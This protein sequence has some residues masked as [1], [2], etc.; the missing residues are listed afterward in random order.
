MFQRECS[1]LPSVSPTGG[2]RCES[3]ALS[4]SCRGAVSI[5]GVH[6]P[7]WAASGI[8]Q[9]Y[10]EPS[11]VSGINAAIQLE[12]LNVLESYSRTGLG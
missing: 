10:S 1:G 4:G 7:L 3:E 6:S 5:Y 2:A 11:I 12:G 9:L 8:F